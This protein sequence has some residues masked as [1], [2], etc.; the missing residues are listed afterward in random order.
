MICT[1]Y[2]GFWS[3]I[4]FSQLHNI[5]LDK[6]KKSLIKILDKAL[7]AFIT[8]FLLSVFF[9]LFVCFLVHRAIPFGGDL[10]KYI[11]KQKK[12]KKKKF[13]KFRPSLRF[14]FWLISINVNTSISF[15]LAFICVGLLILNSSRQRFNAYVW[16]IT[17]KIRLWS[18][19]MKSNIDASSWCWSQKITILSLKGTGFG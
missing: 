13:P 1:F 18:W 11:Y 2:R 15:L 19:F 10:S 12:K 4:H 3:L 6:E 9:C 14:Q 16:I 5:I 7:P 8:Y 17:R